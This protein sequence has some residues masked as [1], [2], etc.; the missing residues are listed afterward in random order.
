MNVLLLSSALTDVRPGL[1]FW[2]LVTFGVLLFVLRWKAWRPILDLV[3]ERERQITTSIETAKKERA[4]AERML[5]E[6][7][8]AIAEARRESAEH[9]R[10][11]QAEMETFREQLMVDARKRAEEEI[12]NARRQIQ[13]EKTK[14]IAEVKGL[15]VDLAL[16][17]AEKL[18][19]EKLDDAKHRQLA[20]QFIDQLAKQPRA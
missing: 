8:A 13:E 14:A 16:Q 12:T 9:M 10:K 18:L 1:I 19:A 6:Q 2:T 15:A 20:E 3:E 4:E 7:K 11:T 17:A 5:T